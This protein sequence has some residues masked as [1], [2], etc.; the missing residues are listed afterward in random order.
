MNL[1]VIDQRGAEH[2]LSVADGTTLM[3]AL[4]NA[5]LPIAAQCGGCCSCAT[6]HIYVDSQWVGLLAPRSEDEECML[7][8][9][10][11][12]QSVSRLSCQIKV[13]SDL[14]GLR[15]TLAPGSEI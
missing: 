6:C 5:G 14:D 7:E 3:E 15:V 10:Q 1:T 13:S 8:L 11:E 12:V 9:A 4:R 2:M